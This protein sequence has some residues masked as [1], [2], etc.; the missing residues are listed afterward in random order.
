MTVHH[1][2]SSFIFIFVFL[3]ICWSQIQKRYM[4]LYYYFTL[5]QH[6]KGPLKFL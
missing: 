4:Q 1:M 3:T 5:T 2:Q 6:L